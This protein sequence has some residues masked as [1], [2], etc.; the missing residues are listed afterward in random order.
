MPLGGP[1]VLTT[2]GLR[3]NLS[4]YRISLLH[5]RHADCFNLL[6][7]HVIADYPCHFGGMVSTSNLLAEDIVEIET[8]KPVVWT[9]ELKEDTHEL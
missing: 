8:D 9:V 4:K 2:R 6:T 7:D 3:W 5:S 1:I